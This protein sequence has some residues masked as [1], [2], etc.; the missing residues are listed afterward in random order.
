MSWPWVAPDDFAGLH[1]EMTTA[2][3]GLMNRGLQARPVEPVEPDPPMRPTLLRQG[4][5]HFL[6]A[7]ARTSHASPLLDGA[8][9][10]HDQQARLEIFWRRMLGGSPCNQIRLVQNVKLDQ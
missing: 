1:P 9:F 4:K 8:I 2:F 3:I 5:H 6:T 10:D 7:P